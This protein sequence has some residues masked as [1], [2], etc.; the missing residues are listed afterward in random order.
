MTSYHGGKMRIGKKLAKT[1]H[2]EGLKIAKKR[3]INIKGYCEPFCGML[4]VYRHIPDTF[5]GQNIVYKA[6]D[7]NKNV[8]EMWK[9]AKNGWKPPISC[10]K[11]TY[12]TLKNTNKVS[13]TKAFVGHV[14]TYRG[15]F[16]G[17][18]F[19]HRASKILANVKNVVKVGK[20]IKDNKISFTTGTY[21]KFSRLKGYI[22]YCDPPYQNTEKRYYNDTKNMKKLKFDHTK[23][24]EWCK[25]MSKH[26]VVIV[27]EY[28][29]PG[30][31]KVIHTI[32]KKLTGLG[33]T[34]SVKRVEKLF[35]TRG[36][37]PK[38]IAI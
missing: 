15:I 13:A 21:T 35:T 7:I 34:G 28:T 37:Y 11:N 16:F 23:F 3:G 38:E 27:S 32:K 5:E 1:I 26:N 20:V 14:C 6:R 10:T 25:K 12:E 2:D 9:S 30:S 31:F 17:G 36:I 24:W 18:F 29:S 4:G 19:K 22:I 33:G 8:I